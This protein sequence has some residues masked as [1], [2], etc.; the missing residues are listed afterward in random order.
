[1]KQRRRRKKQVALSEDMTYD[2]AAKEVLALRQILA[3]ILKRLVPEFR[4][5]SFD[6]IARDCIEGATWVGTIPVA[7]G[8]TNRAFHRHAPQRIRG[9]QTEQ[10][11]RDEG[12]ITYDVLFYARIPD[13]EQRIKFIINVEAQR[14]DPSYKLMKRAIFYASRLISSQK[15]A[16]HP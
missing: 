4:M 7:P 11:E 15:E 14:S 6:T 10:S 5:L 16:L 1:M 12:W 13:T 9:L 8:R 3:P 2:K